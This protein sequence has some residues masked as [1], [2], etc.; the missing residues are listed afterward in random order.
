MDN[1]NYK[2]N[3]YCP[4][5]Y[6]LFMIAGLFRFVFVAE[7]RNNEHQLFS[8]RIFQLLNLIDQCSRGLIDADQV[9][10]LKFG[11]AESLLE[12]FAF[13]I[14]NMRKSG[15]FQRDGLQKRRCG[16]AFVD[17]AAG[18]DGHSHI[19][20]PFFPLPYIMSKKGCVWEKAR[21]ATA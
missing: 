17:I 20:S 7:K 15:L 10:E 1:R 5:F 12:L 6:L 8:E 3:F 9:A 14:E 11:K 13:R 18:D 2:T 16:A 21:F 4:N 19:L